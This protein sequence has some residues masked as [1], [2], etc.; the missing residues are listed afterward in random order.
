MGDEV[1]YSQAS[2]ESI[3]YDYLTF[4][5]TSKV[6]TKLANDLLEIGKTHSQEIIDYAE[7]LWK[8][9][10]LHQEGLRF[11]RL[12]SL[13]SGYDK[14]KVLPTVYL[15]LDV[16]DKSLLKNQFIAAC[17]YIAKIIT[18]NELP[19]TLSL[20]VFG[21]LRF[22]KIEDPA[23]VSSLADSFGDCLTKV[24]NKKLPSFIYAKAYAKTI[25]RDVFIEKVIPKI[26]RQLLR[27]SESFIGI[28]ARVLPLYEFPVTQ[29]SFGQ[30]LLNLISSKSDKTEAPKIL[31]QCYPIFNSDELYKAVIATL[32]SCTNFE[33]RVVLSNTFAKFNAEKISD[34]ILS[35]VFDQIKAEKQADVQSNLILSL[36][37][38]ADRCVPLFKGLTVNATNISS[39]CNVLFNASKNEEVISLVKQY[40]KLSP[41]SV[42][43]VLLKQGYSLSKEE[44]DAVLAPTKFINDK[45]EALLMNG[46]AEQCVEIFLTAP[47]QFTN[48][49]LAISSSL[50]APLLEK[51]VINPSITDEILLKFTKK[52]KQSPNSFDRTTLALLWPTKATKED[53]EKLLE[54]YN[55]RKKLAGASLAE[56]G[57]TK[58]QFE[59]VK[60]TFARY[61][62]DPLRKED[63]DIILCQDEIDVKHSSAEKYVEMKNE[64]AHPNASTNLP[65]LKKQ[66]EKVKVKVI[67]SQKQIKDN[68]NE[69]CVK[70]VLDSI[71]LLT[72]HF[73]NERKPVTAS[74]TSLTRYL[75]ELRDIPIFTNEVE[76]CLFSCLQRVPAFR[77]MPRTI[78][79]ILT[80]DNETLDIE[81]LQY[82]VPSGA[83]SDV[84][85]HMI[86]SNLPALLSSSFAPKF[87]DLNAIT[88]ET[89]LDLLLP[90]YLEHASLSQEI[91]DFTVYLCKDVPVSRL[92]I[93]FDHLMDNDQI[94]RMTALNCIGIANF[95]IKVTPLFLCQLHVHAVSDELAIDLIQTLEHEELTIEQIN[96]VYTT[97]F[98]R[99]SSDETLQ[100]D[101]GISYGRLTSKCKDSAVK[102]LV[103]L[104]NKNTQKVESYNIPVQN[105]VRYALSYSFLELKPMTPTCIDFITLTA[106]KDTVDVVRDN[107]TKVCEFYISTFD[108]SD[109]PDLFKRFFEPLNLPPVTVA[110]NNRLRTCLV[111]LCVKI[112]DIDY[113]QFGQ[114]LLECLMKYNIRSIDDDLRD[115]CAKTIS[116]LAKKKSASL[117]DLLNNLT[118][119]RDQQNTFDKLLGYAYSQC[120]LLHAQGVSSLRGGIFDQTDTLSKSKKEDDRCLACFLFAGLSFMF[121]AIL[122]PSLP[123]VLPVLLAL[124]GDRADV[125]RQA[126]EKAIQSIVKNLTHACV[127]RVLPYALSKVENDE[128]WRVQQA[129]ILLV[130]AV[131][132]NNP[133][134]IAKF[135][136]SLVASLGKA[137]KSAT[138]S[139]REHAVET[140]DLLKT[141][142]S[143]EAVSEIFPF[144]IQ[145]ISNPATL[146]V[147]IEKITHLNLTAKLDTTAL[148]LIV[149]I[150]ANGCNSSIMSLKTDSLK[151]VGQ[152]PIISADGSLDHFSDELIPPLMNGVG[153]SSPNIRAI[154]A[155]SL[156]SL[157]PCFKSDKYNEIMDSLLNEMTTKKTF[158]ERQGNAQAIASLIKTRGVDQLNAQLHSFVDLAKN[159][160]E[161]QVR[162]GYVSLLGF[163]SHFFGEEF[164]SSYN[165]TIE[166]VLDACAD[167]NDAIRTVGLRSASLIAKTFS[168][169]HPKLILTPYFTCALKENWRQRL[170]AVNFMKSFVM[171]TTNTTEA[172]D[173]GIRTIGELLQKL[174]TAVSKELLYPALFTL[175]ILS[176][177][178][179]PTV[180]REA[181]LVWRQVVP[182]TGQFLRNA[183][184]VLL[185]RIA[186]FTRSEFEV[187]RTVG[188]CSMALGIRKLKTRFLIKCFEQIEVQL[189][190]DDID[191]VHGAILSIHMMIELLSQDD[192]MKACTL[193]APFLS[194]PFPIVRQEALEAFVEM[195]DSLGEHGA[196]EV[197][198]QLVKYVFQKAAS[199][200]DVSYLSGLLGILGHH[201]MVDLTNKIMQRPIDEHRPVIAGKIVGA[202]GPALNDVMVGFSER[203]ITMSAHP[204]TEKDG[205]TAINIATNVI[206]VLSNDHRKIFSNK[207]V[208]NMRSQQPQNRKAS[209]IIGGYLLSKVSSSFND[210][211]RALVRASLYLFDDPLEEIQKKAI[212]SIAGVSKTIPLED[213]PQLIKEMCDT[214]ESLCTVTKVRA[215]TKPESFEALNVILE[216]A[217]ESKDEGAVYSACSILATV[218]PQLSDPPVT[219]RKLLARCVLSL[220]LFSEP[221]IQMKLL[222]ASRALFERTSSER[223]MLVNSLPMAYLRLFRSG[224]LDLQT[225]AADA[226]CCYA[227]KVS[228]PMIVVRCLLQIIRTQ[229]QNVSSTVINAL[230]NITKPLKLQSQNCDECVSSLKPLLMNHRPGM[231]ELS[232]QAISVVLL[233]SPVD[234]M[235]EKVT[236]GSILSFENDDN[237]HT[238]MIILNEIL[239][240]T[241]PEVSN[242][243]LPF[244]QKMLPDFASNKDERVQ[245]VYPKVC[246]TIMLC[247]TSLLP[248]LLPYVLDIFEN[249][250]VEQQ[251]VACQELHRFTS[252]KESLPESDMLSILNCLMTA[253]LYGFPAVQSA[254]SSTIFDLF[255]LDEKDDNQLK[256]LAK[257]MPDP[258]SVYESFKNVIEQVQTDRANQRNA[259]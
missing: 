24:T 86:A 117:P 106:L 69:T 102:F 244:V 163:L 196:K 114:V 78:L 135:I 165:I 20:S 48:N 210:I 28:A 136:P 89:D 162:E 111:K 4:D 79:S 35:A 197:S 259:K 131:L 216:D 200:D 225:A 211:V 124:F 191:A 22:I 181:Q 58:D 170:C 45:F 226:L 34:E 101:I 71:Y 96:E 218:V 82:L 175:F 7:K 239:K 188:A 256:L 9:Y 255:K 129:A 125:V 12:L 223:Q 66:F 99:N 137:L 180:S 103:A 72:C 157:V 104:Y 128:S 87:C 53:A 177:D 185:D 240:S 139:V 16:I 212:E 47:S 73:K 250:E 246:V 94:I 50:I 68:L 187:V 21:V 214:L 138:S 116:K 57:F 26:E 67:A 40:F 146:N 227:K 232:A 76:N 195:R 122:E 154:A 249:G 151:V 141:N 64:I 107:M 110:E 161:I 11:L 23:K 253:N 93:A 105:N 231:R 233:S 178:P 38:T 43:R 217:F 84:M 229:C 245:Q 252:I 174:E 126:A 36:Q 123:R 91:V 184:D 10:K 150:V 219:T 61:I 155:A 97:L 243:V 133:R 88:P 149:P 230:I 213:I 228:E 222:Q 77:T 37:N 108:K 186:A 220:Q 166:A 74:L 206:D 90:I 120:A 1:E 115:I 248:E 65:Q 207:L 199:G 6:Q 8:T 242:V 221:S 194:S 209:I 173:K 62:D 192:K 203:M 172:D 152:L 159:S 198:I 160:K 254:S 31:A 60:G 32:K 39:F 112:V 205:T 142:I 29:K 42:S 33:A 132:K 92:Q 49:A 30:T 118:A 54:I 167:P 189:N 17:H 235:V 13:L 56:A 204:P 70:P 3:V 158:A 85:L 190:D 176:A 208:E 258:K 153:D 179:V 171:A 202:A 193:L 113:E 119:T 81:M 143:N 169:S 147:A 238:S 241:I 182:N 100:K 247:K 46:Q 224:R 236:N 59:Y 183:M 2:M 55:L 257:K 15:I 140:I 134:N 237:T 18:I 144:L 19:K 215:F 251:V 75:L 156:S 98:N 51:L 164:S 95:D 234:T 148:S 41:P 83:L 80:H 130:E 127:E 25:P 14:A 27:S 145:A 63:I 44:C 52:V 121:G 5:I 109:L 201:A 168:Q